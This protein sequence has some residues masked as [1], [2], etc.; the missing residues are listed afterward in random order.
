ML[1]LGTKGYGF[2]SR[3]S[4]MQKQYYLNP[5]NRKNI[6]LNDYQYIKSKW[7]FELFLSGSTI[8]NKNYGYIL[9]K[10]FKKNKEYTNIS[11]AIRNKIKIKYTIKQSNMNWINLIAGDSSNIYNSILKHKNK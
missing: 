11:I 10:T 3:Y 5:G 7:L 9:N 6:Q 2:N 8:I 1:V 4:E